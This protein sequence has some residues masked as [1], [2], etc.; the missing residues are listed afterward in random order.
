M[1]LSGFL[2]AP[3]AQASTSLFNNTGTICTVNAPCWQPGWFGVL[4]GNGQT[5]NTSADTAGVDING[6]VGVGTGGKLTDSTGATQTW[7]GPIDFADSVATDAGD[8]TCPAGHTC[9][10]NTGTNISKVSLSGGI[11]QGSDTT[12]VYY[13]EAGVTTSLNQVLSISNYW[14]S[15]ASTSGAITLGTTS[16]HVTIGTGGTGVIVYDVKSIN[17]AN[18]GLVIDAAA[19]SLVI[20]ND[21]GSASFTATGTGSFYVSLEGGIT[22]DDVLFNIT[23]LSSKLTVSGAAN[24]SSY[25]DADFIV[26]GAYDAQHATLDGRLLGWGTATS[27]LGANFEIIAPAD[28][29]VP[30]PEDWLLL[31]GGLGLIG[32]AARKQLRLKRGFP[33]AARVRERMEADAGE[34]G[35]C[36]PAAA[37]RAAGA[38][39]G[40]GAAPPE[41]G[42]P[43][44]RGGGGGGSAGVD[45]AREP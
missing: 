6:G 13:T 4:V 19:G 14:N 29:Y 20:I 5:L 39:G 34:A 16:G 23:S 8:P 26:A 43:P 11:T 33:L 42:I 45:L 36:V 35:R 22:A 44:P 28:E 31:T 32:Y 30:E 9:Q 7:T 40:D 1:L 10:V 21:S 2:L 27:T 41:D 15:Q 3:G 37:G 17:F 24:N 12:G 18:A 38:G 25:L